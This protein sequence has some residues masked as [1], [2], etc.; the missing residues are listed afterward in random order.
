M[1]AEV[2]DGAG[3]AEFI[4]KPKQCRQAGW[5]FAVRFLKID[6]DP[7]DSQATSGLFAR[8]VEEDAAVV[9]TEELRPRPSMATAWPRLA[10]GE[11]CFYDTAIGFPRPLALDAD[12]QMP[13]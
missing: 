11:L 6:L 8:D 9:F 1:A 5:R 2:R 12:K 7:F 10:C 4:V 3:T 13:L